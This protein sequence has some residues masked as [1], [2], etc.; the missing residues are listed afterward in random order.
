MKKE[1]YVRILMQNSQQRLHTKKVDIPDFDGMS[2]GL[3]AEEWKQKLKLYFA[4]NTTDNEEDM[5]ILAVLHMKGK[6]YDW[7][8]MQAHEEEQLGNALTWSRFVT[9][10][11]KNFGETWDNNYFSQLCKLQQIGNVME[12]CET[13]IQLAYKVPNLSHEQ[14]VE[15]FIGGLQIE[16]KADV[17]THQASNLTTTMEL[18]RS[19]EAKNQALCSK[20]GKYIHPGARTSGY[21]FLEYQGTPY[22]PTISKGE[23]KP[24]TM[25][26]TRGTPNRQLRLTRKEQLDLQ[27]KG[28]C[29]WCKDKWGEGHKCKSSQLYTLIIELRE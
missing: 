21:R 6:A 26:E 25:K 12:Y 15:L 24:F 11:Q 19:F 4:V 23:T 13:F 3:R 27:R 7:W 5:I 16:I 10:F 14:R 20:P 1:G 9:A 28:L 8:I 22:P 2:N 18:T 29:Y 17:M